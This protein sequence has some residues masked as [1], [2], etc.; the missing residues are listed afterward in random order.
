MNQSRILYENK[1]FNFGHLIIGIVLIV[2][3]ILVYFYDFHFKGV[4]QDSMNVIKTLISIVLVL[5]GI[6][7]CIYNPREMDRYYVGKYDRCKLTGNYHCKGGCKTCMFALH[8]LQNSKVE[9]KHGK[10]TPDL[11]DKNIPGI[12]HNDEFNEQV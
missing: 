10:T 1:T 7:L 5:S 9:D 12:P 6:I 3:G 8:Y 11:D 2:I 4:D